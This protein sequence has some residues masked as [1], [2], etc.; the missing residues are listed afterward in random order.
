M[1]KKLINIFRKQ[2]IE[3][4]TPQKTLRDV[5]IFDSVLIKD[6]SG[7]VYEGWVYDKTKK[8]I[9]V[10]VLKEDGQYYDYIFLL[11]KS[12]SKTEIEQNHNVLILNQCLQDK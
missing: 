10:T 7:I 1:L 3:T 8:H 5:D 12:G 4:S 6:K 9:I 11:N 2:T